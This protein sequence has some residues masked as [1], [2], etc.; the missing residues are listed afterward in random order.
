LVTPPTP[1]RGRALAADTTSGFL[2]HYRLQLAINGDFFHP[3]AA[4]GPLF[5]Y[6]RISEPVDVRGYAVSR[7]LSY[8]N[9]RPH[10]KTLFVGCGAASSRPVV[11]FTQ[12]RPVC[13]AISGMALIRAGVAR[14]S[15]SK[16]RHP[17]TAIGLDREEKRLFL[18][19]VDGRQ[20]GY[21]EGATMAELAV[22]MQRVGAHDAIALDGGGSS[23][24]VVATTNGPRVLSSPI[25][26]RIVGWERPVANHFG[27][28]APPLGAQTRKR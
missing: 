21:S 17:R 23:V 6:P 15:R 2:R 3:W 13:H 10:G 4:K 11:S 25:H 7:G 19:V 8:G 12:P 22:L 16:T 28:Y 18:L 14:A 9:A 1:T 5:Y 26:G 20:P 24:M 27:V